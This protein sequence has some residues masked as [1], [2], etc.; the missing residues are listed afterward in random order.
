VD[1]SAYRIV[2]ES[3]SNAYRYA[4]GGHVLVEIRYGTDV[5]HVSVSDDGPHGIPQESG[6]GHGLV[7]MRERVAMLDGTLSVGPR[8]DHEGWAVVADLPYGEL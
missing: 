3:L 8:P 4:K 6:G 1:L 2:Q 7:G 5:L